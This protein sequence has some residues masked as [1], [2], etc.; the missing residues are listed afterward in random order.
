MALSVT[1]TQPSWCLGPSGSI[2]WLRERSRASRLDPETAQRGLAAQCQVGDELK[3]VTAVD[4]VCLESVVRAPRFLRGHDEYGL[5]DMQVRA[6]ERDIVQLLLNLPTI[7]IGV[8]VE[9]GYTYQ[10]SVPAIAVVDGSRPNLAMRNGDHGVVRRVA[11]DGAQVERTDF[12]V[13]ALDLDRADRSP[14]TSPM[15]PKR[16]LA[17]AS[18]GCSR[19]CSPT[20]RRS[21]CRRRFPAHA[22]LTA[23]AVSCPASARDAEAHESNL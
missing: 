8:Q 18:N 10:F 13:G 23:S 7:V 19:K 15:T 1:L 5:L 14:V 11:L 22:D 6:D 2:A 20:G 17:R 4:R 21:S 12:A 3:L 9:V 16:T